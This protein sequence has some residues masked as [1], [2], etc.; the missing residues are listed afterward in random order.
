MA[1]LGAP[2]AN[3]RLYP[4]LSTSALPAADDDPDRPLRLLARRLAFVD[5][6]D[7]TPREFTSERAL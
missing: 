2:I 7:G 1:A 4:E 3:D 5:P 6:L